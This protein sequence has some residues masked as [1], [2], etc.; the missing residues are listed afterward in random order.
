MQVRFS[1][2]SNNQC[3]QKK[4]DKKLSFKAASLEVTEGNLVHMYK[5]MD[6]KELVAKW[7]NDGKDIFSGIIDSA[8]NQMKALTDIYKKY[9]PDP[10]V[11]V[12]IKPASQIGSSGVPE[13]SNRIEFHMTP[14]DKNK[15][16]IGFIDDTCDFEPEILNQRVDEMFQECKN[17]ALKK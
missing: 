13:F 2:I 16:F 3:Q 14:V 7:M 12:V 5:N 6:K 1:T 9:K 10:D 15:E 17:S 11:N 8:S 4:C